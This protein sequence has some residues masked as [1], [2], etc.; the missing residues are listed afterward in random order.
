MT[1][2]SLTIII[3]ILCFIVFFIFYNQKE[4]SNEDLQVFPESVTKNEDQIKIFEK[5]MNEYKEVNKGKFKYGRSVLMDEDGVKMICN[6]LYPNMKVL[7]YGSGGSTTMFSNFV[8]S[9]TSIEHD[10]KWGENMKTIIKDLNL[11]DIEL[12]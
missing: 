11:Q 5:C 2:N 10:T 3:S 1:I 7:E 6:L 12:L 8:R 9:W 4:N